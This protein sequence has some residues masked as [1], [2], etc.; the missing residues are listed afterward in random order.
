MQHVSPWS[1]CIF[2]HEFLITLEGSLSSL[3]LESSMARGLHYFEAS[4]EGGDQES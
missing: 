3:T 2:R 4:E 1:L